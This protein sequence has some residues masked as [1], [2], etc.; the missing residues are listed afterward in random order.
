[1]LTLPDTNQAKEVQ[2]PDKLNLAV[3][4]QEENDIVKNEEK[5]E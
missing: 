5:K 2:D 3:G 1:V 4:K